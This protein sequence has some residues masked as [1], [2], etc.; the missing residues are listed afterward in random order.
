MIAVDAGADDLKSDDDEYFEVIVESEILDKVQSALEKNNITISSAERTMIPQN[1]V[2]LESK[3]AEQMLKIM[4]VLDD[5]DDVQDI[6]AN[7]DIDEKVMAKI[8]G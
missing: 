8:A 2:Q 7:F 4:D 5:H 6:Y 3:Q 1:I